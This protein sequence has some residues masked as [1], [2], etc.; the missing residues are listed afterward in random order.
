MKQY[1]FIISICAITPLLCKNNSNLFS[2]AIEPQWEDLDKNAKKK[3]IPEKWI[4][5]GKITLK[6]R[7]PECVLL[8]QLNLKWKGEKINKVIGSLYEKV[9]KEKFLPI[10]KYHICDSLWKQSEEKLIL[11]FPKPKKLFSTNILYL[12][13]TIPKDLE[14]TVKNGCFYV[15]LESLP[16]PYK[17]YVVKNKI[18]LALGNTNSQIVQKEQK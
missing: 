1:I 4:L 11:Q 18:S 10:E 14:E 8:N 9:P 6:K 5:A 7:S 2:I 3:I 12:V 16:Q 15:D 13:L 17:K